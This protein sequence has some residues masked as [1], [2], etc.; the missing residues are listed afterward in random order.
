MPNLTTHADFHQTPRVCWSRAEKTA[1][2]YHHRTRCQV[3][4][5]QVC[6][7]CLPNGLC[8][9][10]CIALLQIIARLAVQ[11]KA[12]LD[13]QPRNPPKEIFLKVPSPTIEIP[14]SSRKEQLEPRPPELSAP[15]IIPCG[16]IGAQS[17]SLHDA[18]D[19]EMSLLVKATAIFCGPPCRRQGRR[20]G[21]ASSGV[22]LFTAG[23]HVCVALHRNIRGWAR[24]TLCRKRFGRWVAR[25]LPPGD[26]RRSRQSFV[27]NRTAAA[28]I[29]GQAAH[30][31]SLP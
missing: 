6:D 21:K 7:D 19:K 25:R 1:S 28:S 2:C 14:C 4:V 24:Q 16:E 12:S 22:K 30:I 5:E 9:D 8:A 17:A 20:R 18:C 11:N 10:C 26:N 15:S 31:G 29:R 23:W 13:C 3:S 27:T